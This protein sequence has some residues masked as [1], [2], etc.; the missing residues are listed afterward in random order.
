M[1]ILIR[2][3]NKQLFIYLASAGAKSSTT[4]SLNDENYRYTD[5]QDRSSSIPSLIR[6]KYRL[7][8]L[9]NIT[10][11]TTPA[12]LLLLFDITDINFDAYPQ[13]K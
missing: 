1:L 11:Y 13:S 3:L 7:R 5:R 12:N 2:S 10:N 9:Q 4:C 8:Y 6:S